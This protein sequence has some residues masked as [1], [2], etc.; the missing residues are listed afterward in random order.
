MSD[1]TTDGM[2]RELEAELD[3]IKKAG[4]ELAN[5]VEY[6][7]GAVS[8]GD[9]EPPQVSLPKAVV[10]DCLKALASWGAAVGVGLPT[11]VKGEQ[12]DF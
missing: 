3:R 6:L 4:Q 11:S 7:S 10:V 1:G 8:C 9:Y 12:G 5:E 2:I